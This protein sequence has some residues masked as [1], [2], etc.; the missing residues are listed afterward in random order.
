MLKPLAQD[1]IDPLQV[2][3]KEVSALPRLST[4]QKRE[5][6]RQVEQGSVTAAR[7]LTLSHLYGLLPKILSRAHGADVLDCIQEASLDLMGSAAAFRPSQYANTFETYAEYRVARH[8]FDVIASLR[9]DIPVSRGIRNY[10]RV[11]RRVQKEVF[12]K[13]GHQLSL[14]ETVAFLPVDFLQKTRMWK[15]AEARLRKENGGV[16]PTSSE[17]EEETRR[18]IRT[19]RTLRCVKDAAVVED[20]ERMDAQTYG[21]QRE[22]R[23]EEPVI[24]NDL[25]A[26]VRSLTRTLLTARE[27]FIVERRYLTDDA[28]TLKRLAAFL[29]CD[30]M[31]IV[32]LEK[33]AIQKLSQVLNPQD[34]EVRVVPAAAAQNMMND[35]EFELLCAGMSQEKIRLIREIQ[36]RLADHCPVALHNT[37]ASHLFFLAL[38][39]FDGT[40]S[41]GEQQMLSS[42]YLVE[43]TKSESELGKEL[44]ISQAGVNY[45]K[46]RAIEKLATVI[47][48]VTAS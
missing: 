7:E 13:T 33:E 31:R 32:Q 28:W 12:E 36:K 9:E 21:V 20:G 40:L 38:S 34:D 8:L 10:L 29:R 43:E 18:S 45:R 35:E 46:Q 3:R 24:H 26:R 17:I 39:A 11:W 1:G 22:G 27:R 37:P 16:E 6:G 5:L 23:P 25:I 48:D 41:E 42:L 4:E 30:K 44:S 47:A 15:K 14:E 2:Y 19:G